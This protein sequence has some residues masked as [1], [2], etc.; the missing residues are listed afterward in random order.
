MKWRVM[1]SINYQVER[2]KRR[3]WRKG[4]RYYSCELCQNLFGEWIIRRR[5]G[6]VTAKQGQ[7]LENTCDSYEEG[8]ERLRAVEKRRLQRGYRG[9]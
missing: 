7:S 9:L 8:L 1:H 3:D 6:R 4:S 5:W 2:W